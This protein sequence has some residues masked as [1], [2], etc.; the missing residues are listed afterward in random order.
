MKDSGATRIERLQRNL[1]LT[2]A[3]VVLSVGV[4]L[5]VLLSTS[6][7]IVALVVGESS[8]SLIFGVLIISFTSAAIGGASS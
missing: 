6:V 2:R 5:P 7:G 1:R 3:I 8:G 4:L